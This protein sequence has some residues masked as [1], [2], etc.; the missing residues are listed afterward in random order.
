MHE[1]SPR[2][3][4]GLQR[5]HEKKFINLLKKQ[6]HEQ[7]V[8]NMSPCILAWPA[9]FFPAYSLL[10]FLSR[11]LAV[12]ETMRGLK[13]TGAGGAP[14]VAVPEVLGPEEVLAIAGA[15]PSIY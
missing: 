13:A 5:L 3:V 15:P 2:A 10:I 8:G 9:H 1:L 6:A 7:W 12:S 11:R 4:S 14:P